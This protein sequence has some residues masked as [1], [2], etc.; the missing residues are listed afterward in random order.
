MSCL[1]YTGKEVPFFRLRGFSGVAFAISL[2][3][4]SHVFFD[5]RLE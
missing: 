4:D 5:M 1:P 3:Q 2:H